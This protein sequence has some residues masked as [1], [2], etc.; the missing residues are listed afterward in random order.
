MSFTFTTHELRRRGERFQEALRADGLDGAVIL[1]RAD[2]VYLSGTAFQGA[3]VAPAEGD[4]RLLAWRGAGRV[5]GECPWPVETLNSAAGF[6]KA[7]AALGLGGW[8]RIGFEEDVLP[9]GLFRKLLQGT[10][11]GAAFVDASDR[12][13]RIRA[14][15]SPEELERVRRS[16]AVL[17]AG[18]EALRGIIREGMYE[19][20]IQAQMEV[21]M[22]REGDQAAGRT[23]G[24]NAEARGVVACG[25]SAAVDNVFDGPIGQPG[26]NPLA[27]VGAGDGRVAAGLPVIADVTA[28]YGGYITDMTRTY[29]IG[30]LE[31]RFVEAHDFCVSILEGCETRMAA[32]AIP[33]EIYL[34]SMA[35][36]EKAGFAANFMNR[37]RNQVRF[38][39]HGIGLEIDEFPALARRFTDPL[40]AGMVIAVEPK[41][42][43]EDGAVGVE[44]TFV[45]TAAGAEP[46]TVMQRGIVTVER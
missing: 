45:V 16:G 30:P 28:G 21:I 17:S 2:A 12:L 41:V 42:V 8:A 33:E 14:V 43:F 36:A 32:G 18:F 24:F 19:Y 46:V 38:L 9:V 4:L 5:P 34:W 3:V 29:A 15:K 7:V 39:G 44:D 11:P 27:P 6:G 37:G 25:P 23:R 13:R 40:A 22:R 31:A 1:Q 10:W 20:E 26:R 35:E